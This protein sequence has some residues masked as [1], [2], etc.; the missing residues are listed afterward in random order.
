ME[1]AVSLMGVMSTLSW[2][3]WI[4]FV[5]LA[6]WFVVSEL[7]KRKGSGDSPS[8]PTKAGGAADADPPF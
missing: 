3:A 5:A 4:L 6:A 2:V 7:R 1:F 8:G